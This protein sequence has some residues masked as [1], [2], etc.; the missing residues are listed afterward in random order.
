MEKVVAYLSNS[1][2]LFR[3]KKL[4]AE[5][6]GLIPCFSCNTTGIE[7]YMVNEYPKNLPDSGFVEHMVE[8]QRDCSACGGLGYLEKDRAGEND[9]YREYQKYLRL[10]KKYENQ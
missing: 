1:G 3:S 10:K 2:K 7:K 5:E 9:E 8:H 6:D 4:C